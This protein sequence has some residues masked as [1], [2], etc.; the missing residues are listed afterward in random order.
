MLPKTQHTGFRA[1]MEKSVGE[2][3]FFLAT[4]DPVSTLALFVGLTAT[5]PA[6]DRAKIA[7]GLLDTPRRF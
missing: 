2:F 5:V 3:L 4:I 6:Q 1:L 7:C